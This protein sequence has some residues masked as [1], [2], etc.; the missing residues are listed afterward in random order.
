VGEM[1][2][3]RDRVA[4]GLSAHLAA[5]ETARLPTGRSPASM[6]RAGRACV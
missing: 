4:S 6:A 3:L 5:I 2:G 1:D